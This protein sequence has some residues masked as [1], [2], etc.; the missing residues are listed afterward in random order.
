MLGHL[1]GFL[2]FFAWRQLKQTMLRCSSMQELSATPWAIYN[3][4][5]DLDILCFYWGSM[6][7]CFACL[8]CKVFDLNGGYCNPYCKVS[9]I[10]LVSFKSFTNSVGLLCRISAWTFDAVFI[11]FS[12]TISY[13]SKKASIL[14]SYVDSWTEMQRI[15][16]WWNQQL[17]CL[18]FI[19]AFILD[20]PF[21]REVLQVEKVPNAWL[22]LW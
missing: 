5:S 1:A 10:T 6:S 2:F 20:F 7:G 19:R 18:F 14:S 9:Y 13:W 8:L 12:G 21:C 17:F 15:I 11:L 4:Q 16:C 3:I 22:V